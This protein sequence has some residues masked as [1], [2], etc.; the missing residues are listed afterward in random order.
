MEMIQSPNAEIPKG[1]RIGDRENPLLVPIETSRKRTRW[2][3]AACR[4]IDLAVKL[5]KR[6]DIQFAFRCAKCEQP[7]KI[8]AGKSGPMPVRV[9]RCNC[10]D[11]YL[12]R[13]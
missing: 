2:T 11:R 8:M 6:E 1:F 5:L 4:R 3:A 10:T 12:T 13:T 7:M 9:W